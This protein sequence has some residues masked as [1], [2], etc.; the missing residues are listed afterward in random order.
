MRTSPSHAP[1]AIERIPIARS[2]SR[3]RVTRPKPIRIALGAGDPDLPLFRAGREVLPAEHVGPLRLEL[4]EKRLRIVIVDQDERFAGRQI[5]ERLE[6]QR[7]SHA[8][9]HLANVQLSSLTHR[10]LLVSPA[11][12][13]PTS[14]R[15]ST[16]VPT[17][18]PL[19]P[20]A[21]RARVP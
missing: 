16:R 6:D 9:R 5:V 2:G 3:Q 20:A 10:A 15:E 7:M 14:F 12:P 13:V 19:R 8:R 1:P 18:T 21:R 11:G 17:P 4:V